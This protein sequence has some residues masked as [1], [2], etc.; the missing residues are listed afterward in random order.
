MTILIF[1]TFSSYIFSLFK[2][3]LHNTQGYFIHNKEQQKVNKETGPVK[4]GRGLKHPRKL[5]NL[6][7]VLKES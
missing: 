3:T 7:F 6:I 5:D 2:W 1:H 4:N